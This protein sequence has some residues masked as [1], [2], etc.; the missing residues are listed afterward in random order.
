MDNIYVIVDTCGRLDQILANINALF[1]S[2]SIV[3]ET[4]VFLVADTSL[5]WLLAPG[6]HSICIPE[7]LR[8][9]QDWCAMIPIGNPC[10]L[11]TTGLKWNLSNASITYLSF[12]SNR[13]IAADFKSCFG[14]M[15]SSSNTYDGSPCVTIT[16]DNPLVWS[17]SISKLF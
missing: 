5:T 6:T 7:R 14:G 15:V 13:S 10:T 3:N 11:T 16:T 8:D 1:K 4:R 2:A 17:M 12:F 9:A